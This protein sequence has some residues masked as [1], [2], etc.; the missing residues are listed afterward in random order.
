MTTENISCSRG[1]VQT[2]WIRYEFLPLHVQEGLFRLNG[3]Y[4]L[5]Q[6]FAPGIHH[7]VLFSCM[8]HYRTMPVDIY[9]NVINKD[10]SYQKPVIGP[11][12]AFIGLR[13]KAGGQYSSPRT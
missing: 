11:R 2:E 4:S 12:S 6:V 7:E 5:M 10:T 9:N 3:M 13:P 1:L 8:A